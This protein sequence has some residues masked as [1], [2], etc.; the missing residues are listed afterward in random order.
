M[1]SAGSASAELDCA[2]GHTAAAVVFGEDR[3]F[4]SAGWLVS[5]E[6]TGPDGERQSAVFAGRL[7]R[8]V[9]TMR[10]R[11]GGRELGPFELRQGGNARIMKCP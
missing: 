9:L 1:V 7:R 4:E 11:I 8:D 5:E 10:I 2:H 6:G 3:Q